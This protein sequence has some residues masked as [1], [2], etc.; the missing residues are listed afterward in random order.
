MSQLGNSDGYVRNY[1]I[2]TRK[3]RSNLLSHKQTLKIC[4]WYSLADG[5]LCVLI[6]RMTSSSSGSVESFAAPSLLDHLQAHRRSARSTRASSVYRRC[7]SQ[8]KASLQLWEFQ[9]SFIISLTWRSST[10]KQIDFCTTGKLHSRGLTYNSIISL[11][12]REHQIFNNNK[13]K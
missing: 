8:T 12:S 11:S 13:Q 7:P 10:F 6:C 4:W 3:I 5:C 1:L 2:N 9:W